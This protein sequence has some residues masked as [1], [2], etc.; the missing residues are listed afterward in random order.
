MGPT[1]V[2]RSP[3]WGK[4]GPNQG[5]LARLILPLEHRWGFKL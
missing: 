1:L 5:S 2:L 3:A 4:I